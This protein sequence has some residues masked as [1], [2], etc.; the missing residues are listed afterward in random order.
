[1]SEEMLWL[2]MRGGITIFSRLLHKVFGQ[3]LAELLPT[4][5]IPV[6]ANPPRDLSALVDT[7]LKAVISLLAPKKRKAAE[8]R[9][10][11]RPLLSLDGAATGRLDQP[12]EAEVCRAEKALKGGALWES[13]LPGLASLQIAP[14]GPGDDAQ[15]VSLRI[16]R[17]ADG[18]PVRRVA[19]GE[20]ALAYRD[21]NP[22][23]EF[24]LGLS[25][26]GKKLGISQYEGYA[27]IHHLKLKDDE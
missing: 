12:T 9:A 21:S 10:R 18:V 5:V 2:H 16:G 24:G 15:E 14:T 3:S 17:D 25:S 22:F 6:S 8:A 27:L 26:F 13:V 1:M 4:R 7:E 23:D 11:L 19:P 20:A